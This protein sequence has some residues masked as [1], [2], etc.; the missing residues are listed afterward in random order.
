MLFRICTIVLDEHKDESQSRLAIHTTPHQQIDTA[1]GNSD[2]NI[3]L[4]GYLYNLKHDPKMS[5][6]RKEKYLILSEV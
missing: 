5:H 3:S 4:G 6:P 2:S 1:Q